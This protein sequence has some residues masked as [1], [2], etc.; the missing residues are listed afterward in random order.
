M[1]I[2][3]RS[4][5][6]IYAYC[7]CQCLN[8]SSY[9]LEFK[10]VLSLYHR[11]SHPTPPHIS[12]DNFIWKRIGNSLLDQHQCNS[13]KNPD[14]MIVMRN[15]VYTDVIHWKCVTSDV[16]LQ[17]YSSV[18]ICLQG[19]RGLPPGPSLACVMLSSINGWL[20]VLHEMS[21]HYSDVIMGVMASQITSLAIVYSTVHS[22][23]DQRKHQSSTS[24]AFVRRIHRFPCT[25][26]Q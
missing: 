20:P 9:F 10:F 12:N 3:N 5:W 23:V 1:T 24:L 18:A 13:M 22:G 8:E 21:S 6:R 17:I 11:Y 2:H 4:Q 15:L 25:N 16:F 14:S 19:F 26:G 7:V